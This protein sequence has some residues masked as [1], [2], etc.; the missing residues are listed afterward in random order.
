M[1]PLPLAI[2]AVSGSLFRAFHRM[3]NVPNNA[4]VSAATKQP[5]ISISSGV[6]TFLSDVVRDVV[7]PLVAVILA[8][9]AII[10]L[11]NWLEERR[12]RAEEDLML[13][14]LGNID[15]MMFQYD[16]D[17]RRITVGTIQKN[18]PTLRVMQVPTD[19]VIYPSK[20]LAKKFS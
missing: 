16:A 17:S 6:L 13:S 19:Q 1:I 3:R 5:W 18:P 7:G 2:V 10:A 15:V 9:R 4:I 12:T 20:L 14:Q 8:I 11:Y